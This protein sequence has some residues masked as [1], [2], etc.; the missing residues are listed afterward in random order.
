[1]AQAAN[2]G[3]VCDDGDPCT[4]P[5]ACQ[6]GVCVPGAV[7]PGCTNCTVGTQCNDFNPC[8]DNVCNAGV[9]ENPSNLTCPTLSINRAPGDPLC[10]DVT[11]TDTTGTFHID[12]TGMD[13]L[14]IVGGQFFIEW[15]PAVMT[16]TG[17]FAGGDPAVPGGP[18]PGHPVTN[19]LAVN[20]DNAAGTCDIL[21][22]TQPFAPGTDLDMTMAVA[23]FTMVAEHCATDVRFRPPDPNLPPTSVADATFI[24]VPL[25]L[26]DTPLFAV[27]ETAPVVTCQNLAQLLNADAGGCTG[28]VTWTPP[29]ATDTDNCDTPAPTVTCTSAPTAG[30][31]NG[32]GDFPSF[33][34]NGTPGGVTTITCTA[35]DVC[36]NTGS[37]SFD[38]TVSDF[39]EMLVDV[40]LQ[41]AV[42]DVPFD[43]CVN[44]DV[45]GPSGAGTGELDLTFTTVTPPPPAAPVTTGVGTVLITC[46]DWDCVTATDTLHTLSNAQPLAAPVT[47]QYDAVWA[48][49]DYLIGGNYFNDAFI[50]L[51]DFLTLSTGP[52]GVI[53]PSLCG[54][55]PPHTDGNGDGIIDTQDANFITFNFTVQGT[56]CPIV[57]APLIDPDRGAFLDP[58]GDALIDPDG[59]KWNGPSGHPRRG[60][61]T[62]I[63]TRELAEIGLGHFRVADL[64]GDGWVDEADIALYMMDGGNEEP[65]A[66]TPATATP[67]P[68]SGN[69]RHR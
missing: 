65:Q 38:I 44:F 58:D 34:S 39:N 24:S 41:P 7:D 10:Y 31:A 57:P 42:S 48:D 40:Q 53:G 1:E 62:R 17:V 47:T 19:Q 8:T 54:T 14:E 13:G 20:I 46:G 69:T 64:N 68:R 3:G 35:T 52:Q 51:F 4:T 5:D 45:T 15:D 59:A 50:D 28:N 27:D 9:C 37:C 18:A 21:V 49:P 36:G 6:A 60:P 30:L 25:T 16:A 29:T 61:V 63:S 55:P 12:M 23:T 43:R 11:T 26:N 22:A 32:G 56:T 67:T 2:E 33:A 66:P